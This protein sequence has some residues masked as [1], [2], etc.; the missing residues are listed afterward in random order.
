MARYV[1]YSPTQAVQGGASTLTIPYQALRGNNVIG[2]IVNWSNPANTFDTVV[3]RVRLLINGD[4]WWDVGPDA[5]REFIRTMA[6]P[7]DINY[8]TTRGF[9][10][11]FFD[12]L[13]P[14]RDEQDMA[15]L[16]RGNPE[17]Q[18]QFNANMLADQ[19]NVGI[20]Q[21]TIEPALTTRLY[22][23]A[24][25]IPANQVN[26]SYLFS[27]AGVLRA[28]IWPM[29]G[30]AREV[31]TLGGIEVIKLT[32][33]GFTPSLDLISLYELWE[34]GQVNAEPHVYILGEEYGA[35]A[36]GTSLLLDTG[37]AWGGVGNEMTLYTARTLVA[38]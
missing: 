38:T 14:T 1:D 17:I 16:P 5:L 6:R 35:P 25:N 23:Q 22:G 37:A 4:V 8:G 7:K 31:L 12:F 28:A 11:P 3:D 19:V 30:V 15:Q 13:A 20:M 29:T 21:T 2:F 18:I 9:I 10:L 36:E 24:M 34:T 33:D 26:Q 32:G 27:A